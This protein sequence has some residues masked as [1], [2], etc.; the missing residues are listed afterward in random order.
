[1]SSIARFPLLSRQVVGHVRFINGDV[2]MM[3][4][5]NALRDHKHK[6]TNDKVAT[7]GLAPLALGERARTLSDIP[8][9]D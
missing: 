1:M 5:V 4:S 6:T 9:V 7:I 8:L 3:A 2:T